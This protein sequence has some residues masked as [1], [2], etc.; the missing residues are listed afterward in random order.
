MSSG[1]VLVNSEVS[2]DFT[3]PVTIPHASELSCQQAHEG[4]SQSTARDQVFNH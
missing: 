1:N 4:W 3:V 2:C